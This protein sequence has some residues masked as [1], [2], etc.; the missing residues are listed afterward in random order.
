MISLDKGKMVQYCDI[1]QREKQI[2]KLQTMHGLPQELEDVAGIS[3]PQTG[4][5]E[6][7]SMVSFP[8]NSFPLS[9]Q[10]AHFTGS[11]RGKERQR[12]AGFAKISHCY[13]SHHTETDSRGTL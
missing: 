2:L 9:V 3:F 12:L 11:L 10:F 7:L 1:A 5:H 13:T 4:R 8:N 6:E